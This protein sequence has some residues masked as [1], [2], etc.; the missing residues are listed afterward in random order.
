M[1]PDEATPQ[2]A[3][4]A[5]GGAALG[6]AVIWGLVLALSGRELGI[7]AWG[8]GAGV[9]AAASFFGGRGNQ[10]GII[11][12][13]L[14]MAAII[15]GKAIGF[16]VGYDH[17]L[18]REISR[19]LTNYEYQA[20]MEQAAAYSELSTEGDV[21]LFMHELDYTEADEAH[22]IT[23][24]QL[25]E[26]QASYGGYLSE[27]AAKKPSFDEWKPI[28]SQY[29]ARELRAVVSRTDLFTQS[30]GFLDIIFFLLGVVSAYRLANK[31]L[32]SED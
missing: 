7:L 12:G 17:I 30:F 14:A 25:A 21:R 4:L 11:A 16:G 8:I 15:F 26:F 19:A 13:A 29:Y 22:D 20:E 2:M 28:S 5:A 23:D 24:A 9:G 27:L 10:M 18:A 6:G 1:K 31:P 3:L 32:G